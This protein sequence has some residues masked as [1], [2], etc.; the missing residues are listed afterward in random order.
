MYAKGLGEATNGIDG[1]SIIVEVD[2]TNGL[3][4]FDI[5]GLPD[6]AVKE[7]RERVRAALKNSGFIF[8]MTRITV[9]LA[10]ADLRKDGSGLD[11][12]IAIGILV[13]TGILKQDAVQDK[14]FIG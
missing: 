13:S 14:V 3:P 4:S 11:V 2:I 10:P 9:N 12:P 7:S 8:P 6:T 5:V 1:V